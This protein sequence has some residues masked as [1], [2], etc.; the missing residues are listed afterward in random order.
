MERILPGRRGI[1][2]E[3]GPGDGSSPSAGWR[4]VGV[5][6]RQTS[7]PRCHGGQSE[8]LEPVAVR[9]PPAEHGLRQP[10]SPA[11]SAVAGST[12]RLSDPG[13]L[14]NAR[15]SPGTAGTPHPAR[16][17][18][19]LEAPSVLARTRTLHTSWVAAASSARSPRCRWRLGVTAA[20][21]PNRVRRGSNPV[22]APIGSGGSFVH[23]E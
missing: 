2:A 10:S 23:G 12:G 5:G 16:P 11:C 6:G 14:A 21:H 15:A 1:A 3:S 13:S 8:C 17:P 4:F 7:Q 20:T 19:P 22:G 18:T 9:A